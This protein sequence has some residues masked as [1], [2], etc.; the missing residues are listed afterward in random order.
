MHVS[1]ELRRATIQRA[2]NRCEYCGLA[3]AGQEAQFHIDHVLPVTASGATELSN[4]ALACVLCSLRKGARHLLLDPDSAA[5]VSIFNPRAERWTTHF[6]WDGLRV[7]ART[8]V[9][10]ATVEALRLNRMVM[11]AIRHEEVLRGRHPPH[12][13]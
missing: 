6:R 4:L 10:R 5:T 9:G 2:E 13:S 7:V 3:Q 11:L 12:L 1:A 8:A